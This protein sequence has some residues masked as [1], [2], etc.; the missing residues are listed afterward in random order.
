MPRNSSELNYY[1]LTT[2][3]K[4]EVLDR[5]IKLPLLEGP[6]LALYGQ[7]H[8]TDIVEGC[9]YHFSLFC[10]TVYK[11]QN[12]KIKPDAIFE[13]DKDVVSITN[14]VDDIN[15]NDKYHRLGYIETTE[16]RLLSFNFGPQ[17]YTAIINKESDKLKVYS[18]SIDFSH[19][20]SGTILKIVYPEAIERII[21]RFDPDFDKCINA[22]VLQN[23]L[24]NPEYSG[25]LIARIKLKL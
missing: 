1:L 10:D 3:R 9:L 14:G 2:D 25:Y 18:G 13:Y 8:R 23:A 21:S 17:A 7:L 15:T 24:L 4:G 5:R 12:G 6:G 22:D 11:I 19:R 20:Q 16:Y